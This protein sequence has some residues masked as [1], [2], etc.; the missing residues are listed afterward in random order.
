MSDLDTLARAATRELLDTG[1]PD[2]SARYAELKRIRTRR[3]TAKVGAAVAAVIVGVGGWQLSRVGEHRS[4]QPVAP[5]PE[6]GNGA[7]LG[8]H[9]LGNG[10]SGQWATAYGDMNAHLPIDPDADP[11]LQFSADGHTFYYSDDQQQL[12]SWDLVTGTKAVLA[13][14]PASGCR[15]GSVSPDGA[16]AAFLGDGHLALTDLRTGS[17]RPLELPG[18]DGGPAAWSPDGR[19]LAVADATGLWTVR[20]ADRHTATVH[21][22]TLQNAVEPAS[23]VAWSP[24]GSRIAFFDVAQDQQHALGRY[25]LMTT[26]PDGSDL[27]AVHDAGWCECDRTGPPSVAW[28]PDGTQLA[29]ATAD[30]GEDTGV[31]TVRPDGS[32]WTLRMTGYWSRLTWQPLAE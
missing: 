12:A 11:L 9:E 22:S 2:V 31:Y 4:P 32:H 21:V 20:V 16:T 8:V 6:M 3:T 28:S 30:L 25:T 13:P 18:L 5:R 1:I 15:G 17:T 19:T 26:R 27:V 14:C 10:T 23:S 29:V 24:D 7:V